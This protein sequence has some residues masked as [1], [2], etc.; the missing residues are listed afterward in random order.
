MASRLGCTC[1]DTSCLRKPANCR[2]MSSS[3][4]ARCCTRS[5]ISS[6]TF[7]ASAMLDTSLKSSHMMLEAL[8]TQHGEL[9]LPAHV[10]KVLLN[11]LLQPACIVPRP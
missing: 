9:E 11:L 6:C 3:A 2:S 7:L 4:R 8:Q 5:S 1:R 10:L